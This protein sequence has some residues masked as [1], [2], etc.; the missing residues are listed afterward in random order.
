MFIFSYFLFSFLSSPFFPSLSS[1]LLTSKSSH[2]I[3]LLFPLISPL[4]FLF[5]SFILLSYL[6]LMFFTL[7]FSLSISSLLASF[8]PPIASS[9]LL[10][11]RLVTFPS[12]HSRGPILPIR[13]PVQ[14]RSARPC[15]VTP[16]KHQPRVGGRD[17]AYRQRTPAT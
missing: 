11:P 16:A 10:S 12:H 17:A 1:H 7:F 5:L 4:L 13:R 14:C 6:L 2:S 9:R 8:V 15:T 3:S